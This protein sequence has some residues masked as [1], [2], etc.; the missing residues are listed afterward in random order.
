MSKYMLTQI[1][2][3]ALNVNASVALKRLIN[4]NPLTTLYVNVYVPHSI[5]LSNTAKYSYLWVLL[6]CIIDDKNKLLKQLGNEH[7]CKK[8]S[9]LRIVNNN[10]IHKE[11]MTDFF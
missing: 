3:L 5:L 8:I 10:F 9:I 11:G 1:P 6:C 4:L 2:H 7:K